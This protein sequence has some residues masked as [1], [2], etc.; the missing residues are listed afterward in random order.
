MVTEQRKSAAGEKE[1]ASAQAPPAAAPGARLSIPVSIWATFIVMLVVDAAIFFGLGMIWKRPPASG[2]GEPPKIDY[3]ELGQFSWELHRGSNPNVIG[4]FN[5]VVTLE[6]SKKSDAQETRKLL[7]TMK[8]RITDKIGTLL[9]DMTF[10]KANSR[11][12]QLELRK[13]IQGIV[14]EEIGVQRIAGVWFGQPK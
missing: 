7:D 1:E 14:N 13:K 8:P 11:E 6:L 3:Y 5:L 2:P 12:T 4:V 10:E 9:L